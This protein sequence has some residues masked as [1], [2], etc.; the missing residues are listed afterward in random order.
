MAKVAGRNIKIMKGTGVG[1]IMI[2]GGRS[3]SIKINNEPIDVT[4]KGSAGW[5]ELL[6]DASVRSVEMTAGGV[7]SGDE[8]IAAALGATSALFDDYEIRIQGIG[9]AAGSFFF[10][11][12]E[13]SA[14]HDGP[15][16]FTAT[17]MSSGEITWTATP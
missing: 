17:I 8:L 5:K 3:D 12:L 7:L 13:V 10:A 9:T 2:A 11:N 15:G 6:N 16:E 1:A 4:D 14:P